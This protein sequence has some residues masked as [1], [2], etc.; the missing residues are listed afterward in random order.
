[1]EEP[2]DDVVDE[3][4]D[5]LAYEDMPEVDA[6]ELE[7]SLPAMSF[8]VTDVIPYEDP[9]YPVENFPS[10]EAMRRLMHMR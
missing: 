10:P 7:M 5:L 2:I 3:V 8:Y 6:N 9:P 4:M 1:M